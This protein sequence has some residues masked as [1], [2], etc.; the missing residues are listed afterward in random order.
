MPSQHGAFQRSQPQ[1]AQ[2]ALRQISDG[3][4]LERE[5]AVQLKRTFVAHVIVA[6]AFTGVGGNGRG[7]ER[8]PG[9]WENDPGPTR[10]PTCREIS[11]G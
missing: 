4:W 2:G 10:S 7:R 6:I 5:F 1:G 3:R 9:H 11:P 8:H